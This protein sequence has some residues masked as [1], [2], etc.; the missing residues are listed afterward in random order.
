MPYRLANISSRLA[1]SSKHRMK[2]LFFVFVALVTLVACGEGEKKFNYRGLAFTLPTG[3]LVDSML[4]RGFVV[5]SAASDSGQNVVFT[6]PAEHYRVIVAYHG[7]KLLA[8]QETYTVSTNDSTRKMW[9]QLRD[10]LEQE[11]GA[12]PNCPMLKDDHKIANFDASDGII[13]VILENTYK[14]SL[15]VRYTPKADK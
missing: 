1:T 2:K 5:D 13:S 9:Q 11:L 8:I 14:P 3:Q 6:K 12:W 15:A 10:G 7:E 4:A